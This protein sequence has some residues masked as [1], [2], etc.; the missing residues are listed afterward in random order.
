MSS[1]V[2]GEGFCGWVECK[3]KINILVLIA[4]KAYEVVLHGNL[5]H[6]NVG[7]RFILITAMLGLP[8]TLLTI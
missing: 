6:T 4:W 8:P 2:T 1:P 3:W 5:K 7:G